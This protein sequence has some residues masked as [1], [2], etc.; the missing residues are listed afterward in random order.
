[1]NLSDIHNLTDAI[2]YVQSGDFE[3]SQ[4]QSIVDRLDATGSNTGATT[5]LYAGLGSRNPVG[6]QNWDFLEPYTQNEGSFRVLDQTDAGQFGTWLID[7][8]DGGKGYLLDAYERQFGSLDGVYD[9]KTGYFTRGGQLFNDIF[10]PEPTSLFGNMSYRFANGATGEVLTLSANFSSGS[11]MSLELRTIIANDAW[12]NG[13]ITGV[14]GV[15]ISEVS[16]ALRDLFNGNNAHDRAILDAFVDGRFSDLPP[17][18]FRNNIGEAMDVLTNSVNS[19][20]VSLFSNDP[21]ALNRLLFDRRIDFDTYQEIAVR[22][23]NFN[24]PDYRNSLFS[25]EQFNELRNHPDAVNRILSGEVDSRALATTMKVLAVAG[26]VGDLVA[27]GLTIVE[28]NA[29]FDA[30]RNEEGAEVWIRFIFG[31][32]GGAVGGALGAMLGASGG[33]VVPGLGTAVGGVLG[34][35][36]GGIGGSLFGESTGSA[37]FD[38]NPEAFTNIVMQMRDPEFIVSEGGIARAFIKAVAGQILGGAYGDEAEQ[39][40][41]Q[42][43]LENGIEECFPADTPILMADGS[44]KLIEDIVVGDLVAS[45][46][47]HSAVADAPL[48]PKAVTRLFRNRTEDF[49]ELVFSHNGSQEV[50]HATPGHPFQTPT[51]EFKT[52]R[53]LFAF[54]ASNS[55]LVLASG[56]TVTAQATLITY[57]AETAHLFEAAQALPALGNLA[58]DAQSAN[59]WNTYNFEVEGNHTY[60]ANGIRVHNRCSSLTVHQN[61]LDALINAGLVGPG[62]DVEVIAVGDGTYVLLHRED[63][64]IEDIADFEGVGFAAFVE[65]ITDT[66]DHIGDSVASVLD[67]TGDYL[68]GALPGLLASLINGQSL[69][70]AAEAYAAQVIAEMGVD[71]LARIFGL[72]RLNEITD[73]DGNLLPI[74]DPLFFETEIGSAIKGALVSSVVMSIVSGSDLDSEAYEQLALNHSV[75]FVVTQALQTQPWAL[76]EGAIPQELFDWFGWEGA[77]PPLSAVGQG[78]A[79]AA[80]SL[81]VDLLDGGIEDVGAALGQAAIAAGTAYLSSLVTTA[82]VNTFALAGSIVPII[83]TVIGAVIGKILGGLFGGLFSPPPPLFVV[84]RNDDG[85]VTVSV[86]PNSGGYIYGARDGFDDTL[87]GNTGDDALLGGS[88]NNTI[89]GLGGNDN[90]EGR[91]GDDLLTGG[92]GNDTLEGG[93]GNDD[94]IGGHGHDRIEGGDGNDL[95]VGGDGNDVMFGD[96]EADERFADFNARAGVQTLGEIGDYEGPEDSGSEDA[97]EAI[98][99]QE[100]TDQTHADVLLG[101]A[102]NDQI[103]AGRGDD[104]VDGSFGDDVIYGQGGHDVI[105]AG[106]HN[107]YVEGGGGNDMIDGEQGDDKI[108]AGSGNDVVHGD[109]MLILK[110]TPV[111]EAI[112]A[113]LNG[114]VRTSPELKEKLGLHHEYHNNSGANFVPFSGAWNLSTALLLKVNAVEGGLRAIL[115]DGE[116]EIADDFMS[117]LHRNDRPLKNDILRGDHAYLMPQEPLAE[118]EDA[119]EGPGE[120]LITLGSGDDELSLG[121]G[122]DLAYGGHGDDIID[123][124]D[125]ND[126]LYGDGLRTDTNDDGEAVVEDDGN[127]DDVID[128]GDGDDTINGGGGN[129][130]L[131]GGAG[132]DRIFAGS[133]NDRIWSGAGADIILAGGGNDIIYAGDSE[134][135]SEDGINQDIINAGAGNDTVYGEDGVDIIDG[136]SGNDRLYGGNGNDQING[137]DGSDRLSGGNNDDILSGGAGADVLLGGSGRDTLVGGSGDDDLDGGTGNDVLQGGLGD[138]DL[139]GQAGNDLMLGEIGADTLSGGTGNDTLLGGSDDDVLFGGEGDDTLDG[140]TGN[141]TLDGEEGDDL[142]V[143]SDG[144]DTITGGTGH[145]EIYGDNQDGSGAAGA[146]VVNAG[147]GN[148]KVYGGGGNDTLRGDAGEDIIEGGSGNDR[149][150]GGADD[151]AL[152]GGSGSDRVL[153]GTGNDTI[154]GG[155]GN[156]RLEGQDGNDTIE[157]GTG[158]DTIYGGGGNDIV[159]DTSGAEKV[160]LSSGNDRFTSN[161]SD[162]EGDLVDGG[163]GNDVIVGSGG[164]DTLKG[165]TGNDRVYGGNGNDVIEGGSGTD[166]LFGQNGNDTLIAWN[167]SGR[168]EGGN[169]NDLYEVDLSNFDGVILGSAGVDVLKLTG[170]FEP[171]DIV[172]ERDGNDLLVRS[173]TDLDKMI[174]IEAQFTG[175]LTI[176]AITFASTGYTLDLVNAIIGTDGNDNITGTE[177]DDVVLALGGDDVVIGAGGDDFLDGGPGKDV[178]YGNAGNDAMHGSSE[179]DMINGGSGNDSL[180][181]G[182]GNDMLIGGTGRDTFAI[183]RNAGDEDVIADFT[184]GQDKIDLSNFSTKFV[185]V[186]QMTYLGYGPRQQG[187]DV[188]FNLGSGQTL[189]AE[190]TTVGHFDTSDFKFGLFEINGTTGT[191]ANDI[192]KGGSGNDRIDGNGGFD[193]MTGGAGR[194]TFIIDDRSSTID[195]ITDFTETQDVIDLSAF[196]DFSSVHQFNV[197]QTGSDVGIALGGGQHLMLEGLSKGSLDNKGFKFDGFED[198]TNVTRFDGTISVDLE[199]AQTPEGSTALSGTSAWVASEDHRAGITSVAKADAG[200]GSGTGAGTGYGVGSITHGLNGASYGAGTIQTDAGTFNYGGA[201]SIYNDPYYKKS[202]CK[203]KLVKPETKGGTQLD[204]MIYGGNWSEKLYGYDGNDKIEAGEGNDTIEGGLGLDALYG[205]AGDDTIYGKGT[206]VMAC[207][208]DLATIGMTP[209]EAKEYTDNLLALDDDLIYGGSGNDKI[210][211]ETGDD[212]LYGDSGHDKI[213]GGSGNDIIYG[214]SG[215]DIITG[216]SGRD[217]I[218]GGTGNDNINGGSSNDKLRGGANNDTIDGSSGNDY[219]LGDSGADKLIGGSGHDRLV[220]GDHNDH[221]LGGTGNDR[222]EG[223][224]HND[225]L[226]G[227]TGNDRGYGGDGNDTIYG[228]AGNDYLRGGAHDDKIYG[229]DDKDHI[230]GDSGNDLLYGGSHNDTVLGGTGNDKIWGGTGND[231]LLGETGNDWIVGE[232][233][234]D[235][236]HGDSGADSLHGQDGN[237]TVLGGSGNDTVHGNDGSDILYGDDGDGKLTGDDKIYG[238]SGNDTAYGGKGKDYIKGGTGNDLIYGQSGDDKI[239]GESGNDKL[240]GGTEND[241]ISGGDNEDR[242]YGEDGNDRLYGGNH[243]DSLYGHDGNDYLRGDAGNDYLSGGTGNDTLK[244]GTGNDHIQGSTGEDRIYGEDGDDYINGGADDDYIDAG[245]GDDVIYTDLGNDFVYGGAGSDHIVAKTESGNHTFYGGTGSD[246]MTGGNGSEYMDGGADNDRMYGR[247]GN[248]HLLGG[249]GHDY[250]HGGYGMDLLYGGQNNDT[251]YGSYDHDRLFGEHGHDTMDGGAGNDQLYGGD[252]ND[253]LYGKTGADQLFGD[254]G[255]DLLAGGEGADLLTGGSGADVFSY[256]TL[257]E[258]SLSAVDV[259]ADFNRNSDKIDLEALNVAFSDLEIAIVNGNT[260]VS[261]EDTDFVI[262]LLDDDHNLNAGHFNF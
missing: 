236:I 14:N 133:G 30:G 129:N 156:D 148:D 154:D 104:F 3:Y 165:G 167:G 88:G 262:R 157:G 152:T 174:R 149:I 153:G 139:K 224:D 211:G 166:Q 209:E 53:E 109:K 123:G 89:H 128:G 81:L 5:V 189:I 93:S 32:A 26:V 1:M 193:V 25:R 191:S 254:A 61:A 50:L 20:S 164:D 86:T 7:G 259:I 105:F 39:R 215:N 54:G 55:E 8:E 72:E 122:D 34:G 11:V 36:L 74:T 4:L 181:D 142:L 17:S 37:L 222:L 223:G 210:Y 118:G 249:H 65:M 102:G 261:I 175:A 48:E 69:D 183:T 176:E 260:E 188:E 44:E 218:D 203:K 82:V 216:S 83:G 9:P 56:E 250:M 49:Y 121:A 87:I 90:L 160:Y 159:T 173:I 80:V 113:W 22:T 66:I 2:T 18:N 232:A 171:K 117:W 256:S 255:N 98:E 91:G 73:A 59:G 112:R 16:Y 136:G 70:D 184:N 51:G 64:T 248:D 217:Y 120:I 177:D 219:L 97:D 257:T 150:E 192:I 207:S 230:K 221:L 186:S 95:L 35:L 77:A 185:S 135:A 205:E 228:R 110:D 197:R 19:S 202:G 84:E 78:A 199:A 126:V 29:H 244:G 138:D 111:T 76:V 79:A 229:G 75:R 162:L 204:D 103:F 172:L 94:L 24:D 52:L 27:F 196:G 146:D 137:G 41:R 179:D 213:Y 168:L 237:D 247:S 140:G 161:N 194:D 63:K 143:G 245:A 124:G 170:G 145:D 243:D 13:T 85:T 67:D 40:M 12:T 58:I 23:G 119:P 242:L 226:D 45:F 155:S 57:S 99:D 239:Y 62:T 130:R 132:D 15:D 43:M 200:T 21:G 108:I 71:T 127:G 225:I 180:I 234:N 115:D 235:R 212:K 141:D 208:F 169:G 10:A 227:E 195:T 28:A 241:W 116:S 182:L 151:D 60:V 107:D 31:T 47:P 238:G 92:E 158:N 144:A 206:A 131:T 125:G 6:G 178:I 100:D 201:Q 134:S 190:D 42:E 240:Y 187:D 214:G 147:D 220:G 258:S 233:G 114:P 231:Y 246:F 101:G 46:A 252:H 33:S 106:A 198:K 163:S 253:K 251:M 96:S 38:M 68:A